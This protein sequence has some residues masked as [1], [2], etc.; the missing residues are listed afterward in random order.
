MG[1]L[2]SSVLP[3]PSKS[4]AGQIVNKIGIAISIL[5]DTFSQQ[6]ACQRDSAC[7]KQMHWTLAK[8]FQNFEIPSK[9]VALLFQDN[10]MVNKYVWSI[11]VLA[12][13]KLFW[14]SRSAQSYRSLVKRARRETG[15]VCLF[16]VN[17]ILSWENPN[18]SFFFCERNVWKE[19][20]MKKNASL[21]W[22][23]R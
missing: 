7:A 22:F 10:E 2:H 1:G 14:A 19:F 3:D 5:R 17:S 11:K 16:E 9:V 4:G 12:A 15:Y 13:V 6:G 8:A 18:L 23:L 21:C 20:R